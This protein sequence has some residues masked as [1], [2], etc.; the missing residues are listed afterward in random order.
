MIPRLSVIT[1]WRVRNDDDLP[2]IAP[3]EE[4]ERVIAP[5]K[6]IVLHAIILRGPPLVSLQIGALPDV[7]F[8]LEAIDVDIRRYRPSGLNDEA[9][10]K[11]LI[12][13]GA[14]AAGVHAIAI[15]PA[16]E[17]RMV[18]RN[19]GAAPVKPHAALLVQEEM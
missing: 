6:F 19:D 17:V 5:Q 16:L 7:P 15:V 2:D 13:V 12:H 4:F 10:K 18:V 8:E 3:G 14:A 1:D 9:L 11:S